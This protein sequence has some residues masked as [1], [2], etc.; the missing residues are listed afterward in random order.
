MIKSEK[1]KQLL[2]PPGWLP[3]VA[4]LVAGLVSGL[5]TLPISADTAT[6]VGLA[7]FIGVAL[8]SWLGLA[9]DRLLSAGFL[10]IYKR[11]IAWGNAV[12]STVAARLAAL[13]LLLDAKGIVIPSHNGHSLRANDTPSPFFKAG[14]SLWIF[15]WHFYPLGIIGIS[16]YG[17]VIIL[18]YVGG[19]DTSRH[20]ILLAPVVAVTFPVLLF[21]W[22]FPLALNWKILHTSRRLLRR[23]DRIEQQSAAARTEDITLS[24]PDLSSIEK[25]INT[26]SRLLTRLAA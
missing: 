11:Q 16:A 26:P 12:V 23:I 20:L 25:T 24:I 22:L 10:T 2:N 6:A 17:L 3:L 4:G 13:Q 19:M 18:S 8:G 7:W 14:R 15:S 5:L 9:A 1:S 21:A